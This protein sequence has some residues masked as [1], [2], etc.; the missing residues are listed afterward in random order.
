MSGFKRRKRRSIWRDGCAAEYSRTESELR[1][2][3]YRDGVKHEIVI[4]LGWRDH[5]VA[6]SI[7]RECRKHV[8]LVVERQREC[9]LEAERQLIDLGGQQ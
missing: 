1:L 6:G 8:A 9:V 2:W 4:K 3:Q 7:A 5:D